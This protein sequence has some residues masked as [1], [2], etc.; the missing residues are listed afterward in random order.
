MLSIEQIQAAVFPPSRRKE[1][2]A[3]GHGA[4][5]EPEVESGIASEGQEQKPSLH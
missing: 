4:S 2:A 1:T 3:A 5:H